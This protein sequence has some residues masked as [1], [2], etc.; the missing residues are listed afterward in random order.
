LNDIAD[1]EKKWHDLPMMMTCDLLLELSVLKHIDPHLGWL[2]LGS[3][4]TG[5]PKDLSRGMA[6]IWVF[7]S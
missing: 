7:Y 3:V 1:N 4:F 5:L 2:A 6:S